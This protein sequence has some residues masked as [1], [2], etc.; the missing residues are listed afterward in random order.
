MEEKEFDKKIE[1]VEELIKEAENIINSIEKEFGDCI[2]PKNRVIKKMKNI[3]LAPGR[4]LSKEKS[5]EEVKA[6]ASER[7]KVIS[8]TI[9][10]QLCEDCKDKINEESWRLYKR[11]HRF[12]QSLISML[13]WGILIIIILEVVLA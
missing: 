3:F 8:H 2:N 11:E 4:F 7:Q 12:T 13:C 5:K 1:E 9:Y 6:D 10:S